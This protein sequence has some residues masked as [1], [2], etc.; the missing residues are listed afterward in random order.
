[1]VQ[2]TIKISST[3]EEV[4]GKHSLVL[5]VPTD[6][7]VRD[8]L[9]Q[10]ILQFEDSLKQR[11]GFKDVQN[12]LKYFIILLNGAH[13]SRIDSLDKKVDDGDMVEIMEL[14]SGG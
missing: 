7:S 8:V 13:L 3:L 12:F 5:T 1:M 14:V 9:N 10:W 2:V 4:V 11:Y 6:S